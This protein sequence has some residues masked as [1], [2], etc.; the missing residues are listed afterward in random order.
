LDNKFLEGETTGAK[1]SPATAVALLLL[2]LDVKHDWTA[3]FTCTEQNVKRH[4]TKWTKEKKDKQK[5]SATS[6]LALQTASGTAAV[7]P[8][9]NA[10]ANDIPSVTGEPSVVA[11]DVLASS[12]AAAGVALGVS[13]S[14]TAAAGVG[15]KLKRT[16]KRKGDA[17]TGAGAASQQLTA[18]RAKRLK[19]VAAVDEVVRADGL[20]A[21]VVEDLGLEHDGS[22]VLDV[23][24][25]DVMNV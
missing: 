6:A 24:D 11:L 20:V 5:A 14:S 9:S 25:Y 19:A 23:Y 13:A 22:D 15:A 21:S 8:I 17:A 16:R 2:R 18:R 4:F 10:S 3:R 12:T 1:H 7:P